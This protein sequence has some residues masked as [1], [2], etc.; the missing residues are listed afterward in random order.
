MGRKKKT[1][2][3]HLPCIDVDYIETYPKF[4]DLKS[5]DRRLFNKMFDTLVSNKYGYILIG[6]EKEPFQLLLW[7]GGR[8]RFLQVKR[9]ITT[10][11]P[12]SAILE[13]MENALIER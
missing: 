3:V 10:P 9:K 7:R 1:E 4:S 8:D 2:I 5:S 6:G 13:R 11:V 12:W